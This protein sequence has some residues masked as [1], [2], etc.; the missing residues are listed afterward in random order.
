MSLFYN[1][2]THTLKILYINN[3]CWICKSP[4]ITGRDIHCLKCHT[5]IFYIDNLKEHKCEK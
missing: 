2:D 1:P 3:T 4:I 5:N